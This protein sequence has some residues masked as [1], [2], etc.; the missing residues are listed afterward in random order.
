MAPGQVFMRSNG[1]MFAIVCRSNAEASFME[2]AIIS[3]VSSFR[4]KDKRK[5]AGAKR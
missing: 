3:A 4:N 2:K 1:A 5:K